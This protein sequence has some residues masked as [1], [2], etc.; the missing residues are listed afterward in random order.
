M[1][2]ISGGR[3]AQQNADGK[4]E[5]SKR[6]VELHDD[7]PLM[8]ARL[9]QF[10]Y[11]GIYD[12][13]LDEQQQSQS[14]S[15]MELVSQGD[16]PSESEKNNEEKRGQ[17]QIDTLMWEL[18]NKY[19]CERLR[20]YIEKKL[21]LQFKLDKELTDVTRRAR[22]LQA[23]SLIRSSFHEMPE[24]EDEMVSILLDMKLRKYD[25]HSRKTLAILPMRADRRTADEGFQSKVF[26]WMSGNASFA[27]TIAKGLEQ[28]LDLSMQ[29]H[30]HSGVRIESMKNKIR[31]L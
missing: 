26:C 9:T 12:T 7:S 2:P 18:A 17:F 15:V 29:T 5:S 28:L 23:C 24:I 19:N 31:H 8:I 14:L 30:D 6:K 11:L 16:F 21:V 3:S 10:F 20:E 25:R 4:Q 1:L 13:S 22:Y 27:T